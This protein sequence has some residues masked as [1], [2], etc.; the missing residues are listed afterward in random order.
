M[1]SADLQ[2]DD[3]VLEVGSGPGRVALGL[4]DVLGPEGSYDG[5][6][7]VPEAVE[8]SRR[9]ITSMRPSFRFHLA[10]VHNDHYHRGGATRA[11]DYRFPFDDGSFDLV[12][13]SSV[14]THLGTAP[15]RNY[16]EE[17]ARVLR[18]GGRL[19]ATFF[20]IDDDATE[21]MQSGAA[22]FRFEGQDDGSLTADP[23]DPDAAVAHHE[24]A[25]LDMLSGSGLVAP[26]IVRG[27][28]SGRADGVGLQDAVVASRQD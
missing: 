12:F 15:T 14:F 23:R 2:P 19:F 17:S 3:R 4:L 9:R 20:L 25:V 1:R 27:N 7:I 8:W 21:A 26:E 13:L 24:A 5:V 28:W 22:E 6:E 11:E 16:I 18:P 10:D